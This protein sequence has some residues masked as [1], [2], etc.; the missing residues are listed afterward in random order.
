[1]TEEG[2]GHHPEAL[3]YRDAVAALVLTAL[4]V[5]LYSNAVGQWWT[6]DDTQILK[7]ALSHSLAAVFS[8]PTVWREL[9]WL[10]FTPLVDLSA[11]FDAALFGLEPAAWYVRHLLVIGLSVALLYILMRGWVPRAA[12]V[13]AAILLLVGSPMAEVSRQLWARHYVEGLACA[14]LSLLLL[15]WAVGRG[16]WP[17]ALG[18]G[19]AGLVAMLG[20]EVFA[21]IPFVALVLPWGAMRRRFRAS[22]P[23]FVALASYLV[24]RNAMVAY[25]GGIGGGGKALIEPVRRSAAYLQHFPG[26]LL[27][28]RAA[29]GLALF[30]LALVLLRP[31]RP[32]AAAIV[33]VTGLVLAP[34]SLLSDPPAGRYAIVPLAAVA[35]LVG[36][37][38]GTG[39][40]VG[41]V[42]RLLA[43]LLVVGT[44]VPALIT[45]RNA[46]AVA[47]PVA[48]R[49]RAEALFYARRSRQNDVLYRPVE[50]AWYFDGLDWLQA[51]SRGGGTGSVVYDGVALC[52]RVTPSRIFAYDATLGGVVPEPSGP[53]AEIAATC[54]R[55]DRT[56]PLSADLTYRNSTLTWRLGPDQVGTWAF[57]SGETAAPFFVGREGS[58]VIRLTGDV[59]LRVK[60][61]TPDDR[62]GLSPLLT[63]RVADGR[64][65]LEW[66]K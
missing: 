47:A 7:H 27:G 29:A 38:V 56:M 3:D 54:A 58:L 66:K 37:A 50:P 31:T 17:A 44:L 55:L 36:T 23:L 19:V 35:A 9:S 10:Y 34:L 1:L 61:E 65:D 28:V 11:R 62:L 15:R 41:G 26:T 45:G 14:F 6:G 60:H 46:F 63:L 52:D 64:G 25:W 39:L 24:W 57:L 42:R 12:S 30:V 33:L 48:A 16:G 43:V 21:A 20:K 49:S 59:K 40:D 2:A 51:R 53:V 22:V 18:A 8:V 32:Q 4:P 13:T 5:G